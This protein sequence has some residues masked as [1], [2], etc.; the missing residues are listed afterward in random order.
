MKYL[1]AVFFPLLLLSCSSE[2]DKILMSIEAPTVS[3]CLRLVKL[4]AKSELKIL[5]DKPEKVL[6]KL[7]NGN[8]FW[9]QREVTGSKGT[10]YQG[11]YQ[12]NK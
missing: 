3:E 7:S 6:G 11:V 4:N 5:S 1:V 8:M 12:V 10:Y 9:C 2:P